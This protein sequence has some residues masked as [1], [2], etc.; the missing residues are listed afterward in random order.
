MNNLTA[1]EL[2][3]LNNVS[4]EKTLSVKLGDTL[5]E[6]ISSLSTIDTPANAVAAELLL[7]IGGVVVNGETITVNNPL[8][9]GTDIYEFLSDDAQSK[10]AVTNIA[11]DISSYATKSTG[12]LTMDTKPIA[13]DKVTIGEKIFTFV[14]VG[15]DTADGEVSVGA[16]LAGA[17]AA[18]VAAINGTDGISEPHMFVSAG[19]FSANASVITALVGGTIGDSIVTTETFT[20][21]TN[22]FASG[23]LGGGADCTA[24]NAV[25]A[26]LAAMT[27]SDTQGV[28]GTKGDGNTVLFSA[29]DA[30]AVGNNISVSETMVN[31]GFLDAAVKLSGGVDGT[32]GQAGKILAEDTYLYICIGANDATGTNWRRISLGSVY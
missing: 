27:A 14:P 23:T 13:G 24:A 11:V 21:V 19:D 2:S 18:L 29:D 31:G 16:D 12:T 8:E 26:L 9:A 5:Q 6:V 32:V 4:Q 28:G 7:S 22:I 10:S 3:V 1:K 15:T 30:G 20:A 25:I 17:Q